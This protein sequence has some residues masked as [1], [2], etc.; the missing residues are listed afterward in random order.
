MPRL[1]SWAAIDRPETS[2]LPPI[3]E[4]VWQQPQ[5]TRSID[6]HNNSATNNNNSTHTPEFKRKNDVEAQTSP[7]QE[8]SPQVSGSG[9]ESLLENQTRS[10]PVQYP[11]DPKKRQH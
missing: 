3:P 7:I 8:T 1:H 2:K 4:V 11:N 5:E 6:V 10:T 9:T